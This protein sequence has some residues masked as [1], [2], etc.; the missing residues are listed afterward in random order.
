V[1]AD[2]ALLVSPVSS[3]AP[4]PIDGAAT[5]SGRAFREAVMPHT[6]PHDLAGIPSCAVRA[7]FDDDGLPV[8]IQLAAARGRDVAVL[9]AA[10][11]FH[12]ATP[13]IQRRWP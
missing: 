11:A 12:A 13:E 1:L 4:I 3:T 6:V 9:E 2:G 10:A 7:G 5:G 8:G